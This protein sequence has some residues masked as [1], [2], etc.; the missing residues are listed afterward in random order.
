MRVHIQLIPRGNKTI[1][2]AI[3]DAISKKIAIPYSNY[4]AYGGSV[5]VDPAP[6][7]PPLIPLELL[8]RATKGAAS[9][10]LGALSDSKINSIL[11]KQKTTLTNVANKYI[12]QNGIAA[13]MVVDKIIKEDERLKINVN[14]DAIDYEKTICKFLPNIIDSLKTKES[15][16]FFWEIYDI[17]G[18]DR[19]TLVKATLSSLTEEQKDM[20]VKLL[21][22]RF[23]H[24][25]CEKLTGFLAEQQIDLTVS[26]ISIE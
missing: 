3:L 8:K 9:M 4:L 18:D 16:I 24:A 11:E 19:D 14:I 13:E 21:V 20:I 2:E 25:I 26:G 22:K 1:I 23:D 17:I 5:F 12:K 7:I 6:P 10:F 15:D